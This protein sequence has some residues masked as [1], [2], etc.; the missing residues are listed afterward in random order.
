MTKFKI[1]IIG[2]IIMAGSDALALERLGNR[3]FNSS[4]E[5]TKAINAIAD[6]WV[7][8]EGVWDIVTVV[9]Q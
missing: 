2:N 5:A 3:G 8:P 6:S 7:A 1:E 4:D 9:G